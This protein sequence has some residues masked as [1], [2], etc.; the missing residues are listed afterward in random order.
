MSDERPRRRSD[1]D[2]TEVEDG[3]VAYDDTTNRV[4]HLNTPLVA[5]FE[6]ANGD[7]TVTEIAEAV[8]ADFGL[9]EPPLGDVELATL[10]VDLEEEFEALHALL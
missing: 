3:F 9:D 5:V 10:M 6:L 8:A 4:H 1:L 2:L 7:R